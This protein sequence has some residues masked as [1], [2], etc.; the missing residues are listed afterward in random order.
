[1]HLRYL[2]TIFFIILLSTASVCLLFIPYQ[3]TKTLDQGNLANGSNLSKFK[4]FQAEAIEFPWRSYNQEIF[5]N[6]SLID[7]KIS[8]QLIG[9]EDFT[10][11]LYGNHYVP[12][13]EVINITGI[14][15]NIKISPQLQGRKYILFFV[16]SNAV[17]EEDIIFYGKVKV[18][19]LRYAS[20]YGLLFL[21]ISIILI[22][23]YGYQRFKWKR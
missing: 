9:A 23:Y 5:L 20:S 8:I 13:W 22:S 16:D 6:I 21:G 10:N 17:A 2:R 7:G 14:M 1:M 18:C 12:Y 15:I 19:Y 4:T 3:E 11:F